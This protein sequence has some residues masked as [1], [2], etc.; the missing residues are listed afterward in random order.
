MLQIEDARPSK[1]SRKSIEG[2]RDP[3]LYFSDGNIVLFASSENID[4]V[5]E[6]TPAVNTYFRVHQSVLAKHSPVFKDMFSLPRPVEGHEKY[7]DAPLVTL[8]DDPRDLKGFLTTL[9]DP[10][11]I[12]DGRYNPDFA[13]TMR[14]PAKL[15]A[16]YQVQSLLERVIARL[17]CDW[18]A[19]IEE[20]YQR[21][22]ELGP[23]DRLDPMPVLDLIEDCG[24]QSRLVQE[25]AVIRYD[26]YKEARVRS[27]DRDWHDQYRMLFNAQKLF[28][29]I[30]LRFDLSTDLSTDCG[31]CSRLDRCPSQDIQKYFLRKFILIETNRAA[32][33]LYLMRFAGNANGSIPT[34]L[35]SSGK[36]CSRNSQ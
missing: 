12:P 22:D 32:T 16:K 17:K 6:E 18:P 3:D 29:D 11:F 25:L 24:M 23:D 36:R 19:T 34:N 26:L 27:N 33:Y 9:Y 35:M 20:Y 14:G 30:L 8:Y 28:H 4:T 10:C 5:T 2:V 7:D 21:E 15:A 31:Y 13:S 1:R